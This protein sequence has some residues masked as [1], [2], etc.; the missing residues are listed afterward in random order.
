M[1]KLLILFAM[2]CFVF[3]SCN[4]TS[5]SSSDEET[6]SSDKEKSSSTKDSGKKQELKN[7]ATDD[8][9][10]V[11]NYTE[12]NGRQWSTIALVDD[13]QKSWSEG[14]QRQSGESGIIGEW[15]QKRSFDEDY[16]YF[17]D[18]GT[19]INIWTKS[20]KSQNKSNMSGTY[21]VYESDGIFKMKLSW[22]G[23]DYDFEY[24]VSDNYFI[25]ESNGFF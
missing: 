7:N 9:F 5:Q 22:S 19:F 11:S 17:K 14:F 20:I 2:L 4:N 3:A 23:Y 8:M 6:S 24:L 15:I 10:D 21:S 25:T 18:D 13:M 1:K 16:I 12:Q